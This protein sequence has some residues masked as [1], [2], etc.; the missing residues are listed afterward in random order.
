MD[1]E[2][3]GMKTKWLWA[4]IIDLESMNKWNIIFENNS[5]FEMQFPCVKS[6]S[7]YIYRIHIDNSMPNPFIYN[8]LGFPDPFEIDLFA[9]SRN[10][11]ISPLVGPIRFSLLFT[12]LLKPL[13]TSL[14]P[15][16][17]RIQRV[18]DFNEL[19]VVDFNGLG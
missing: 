2:S 17:D 13:P 11:P 12:W 18:V 15:T 19:R 16:S 9:I 6:K 3:Q 4:G 10:F 5:H 7:L 14:I 8:F 1:R